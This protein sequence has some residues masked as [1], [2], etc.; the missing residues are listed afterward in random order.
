MNSNN[1]NN[2][3]ATPKQE[4][5]GL[6]YHPSRDDEELDDELDDEEQEVPPTTRR[7]PLNFD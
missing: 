2:H 6:S 1:Q 7:S 5:L 3:T 4:T